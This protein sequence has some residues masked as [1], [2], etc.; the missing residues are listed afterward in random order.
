MIDHSHANG[1]AGVIAGRTALST[2]GKEQTG[3]TY[4]GYPIEELADQSSFEEVAHLLL[5]GKL[6]TRAALENYRSGLARQRELPTELC[7][8]LEQLPAHTHPMDVLRTGCSALGCLEPETHPAEA[9]RVAERM[10]GCLPSILLYW[11]HWHQHGKRIPTRSRAD[12]VAGHFLELLHGQPAISLHERALD[13][14]LILYAEHE[15]NASTF[16]ARVTAST[17]SDMYSALTTGIGTLRGSLHGGANE[18]AMI[19]LEQ[20]TDVN[21]A[22]EGVQQALNRHEKIMGFGHRVYKDGDPRSDIIKIWARQL[23]QVSS[24]RHLFAMAQ[25]V[26][27][28]LW[29][30]KNL[31]PNLDFYSALVFRYLGIPTPLFTPVFAVARTAGWAAHVIEQ[32]ADN[33]LIRPVA[34]YDGPNTR[35]VPPMDS[36]G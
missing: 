5:R 16:A 6:P 25:R 30:E 27:T 36:R 29:D 13:V 21:S 9:Q 17:L 12:T 15:F 14:A 11:H 24:S 26:E 4:R 3:L 18:A 10:I 19:W 34:E 20:F 2:V 22:A 7:T 28:I 23:S 32:R 1:L 8:I 35:Q 33:R 31:S